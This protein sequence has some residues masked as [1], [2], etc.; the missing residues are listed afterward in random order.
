MVQYVQIVV[1]CRTVYYYTVCIVILHVK[2]NINQF[3]NKLV[4]IYITQIIKKLI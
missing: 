3:L 1:L 2:M 4:Y